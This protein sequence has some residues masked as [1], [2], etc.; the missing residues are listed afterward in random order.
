MFAESLPLAHCIVGSVEQL[1]LRDKP[2]NGR[3][4]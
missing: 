1:E 4:S 2:F 3:I